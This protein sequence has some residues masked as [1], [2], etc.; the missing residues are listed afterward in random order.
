M[1]SKLVDIKQQLAE[2]FSRL[3][4]EVAPYRE[5]FPVIDSK[6]ADITALYKQKI[7]M[8]KPQIMVF[9]IYNA[10]KSSIL[11]ELLRE[12]RAKVNDVPTTDKVDNY[13]WRGYSIADTPGVGAPI[14]HEIVTN[15]AIRKADVVLFVMTNNGSFESKDNYVR[16]KDII[17]SGKKVIIVINDKNGDLPGEKYEAINQVRQKVYDNMLA[18]GIQNVR[19]H[20]VVVFVNAMVAH[21]ARE[22]GNARFWNMSGMPELESVI[23][24]EMKKSDDF[25]VIRHAIYEINQDVD[26]IRQQINKVDRNPEYEA[27]QK[28]LNGL[29][30][31][32]TNVRKNMSDFITSETNKLGNTLPDA[33]WAV[34]ENQE[35]VNRIVQEAQES[36][37]E[38][39]QNHLRNELQIVNDDLVMDWKNFVVELQNLQLKK[40]TDIHADFSQSH[41]DVSAGE[42][43]K[44]GISLGE[45]VSEGTALF[46]TM[47]KLTG[48]NLAKGSL[49]GAATA[50]LGSLMKGIPFLAKIPIPAVGVIVLGLGILK[51]LFGDNSDYENAK[52]E[53]N[54]ENAIARAKV[55]AEGQA[56]QALQQKCRYLADDIR[57][58]LTI[59]TNQMIRDNIGNY[60]DQL[61]EKLKG[62][63]KDQN[64]ALET[65]ASLAKISDEYNQIAV[66][67]EGSE[68]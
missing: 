8:T 51:S 40:H 16:M 17:S 21:K 31:A 36:L 59:W 2:N 13:L 66:S 64:K 7:E 45:L 56:R 25:H 44:D 27:V 30:R 54:R 35:E 34:K 67:M 4:R 55:E 20:F 22:M 19:A 47:T 61:N 53:A 5:K 60:E 3:T 50:G 12:D 14:E 23:L 57:E 48:V 32:K 41:I 43:K 49:A 42:K 1:D 28:V 11:N 15:D 68:K 65:A 58:S 18:L 39:V 62:L 33:V 26:K 38:K 9:G 37:A 10:G 46:E 24:S 29:R 6:M 52:A 63:M